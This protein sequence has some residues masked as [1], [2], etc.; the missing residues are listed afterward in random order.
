MR[1]SYSR[2]A[3]CNIIGTAYRLNG[4]DR[5]A[6]FSSVKDHRLVL[7][8][9]IAYGELY[10]KTVKL[11]LRQ[12]ICSDIAE[13]ILCGNYHKRIGELM[14]DTVYRYLLLFHCFKQSRLGFRGG[15]VYF[16][17]NKNIAHNKSVAVFKAFAFL[18]VHSKACYIGRHDIGSELNT[19][20][21]K[22]GRFSERHCKRCFS[23]TRHVLY[24][25]MTAGKQGGNKH[26]HYVML[27]Y[28]DFFNLS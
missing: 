16:I 1:I 9:G 17:G 18:I 27:A 8:R 19:S 12:R 20:A 5:V 23:R 14:C 3:T 25:H 28:N 22:R 2:N 24:Q 13:F 4:F 10:K 7:S 21:R 11:S 6:V 15:S 26:F